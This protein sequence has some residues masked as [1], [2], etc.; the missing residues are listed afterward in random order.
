MDIVYEDVVHI[1]FKHRRLIHCLLGVCTCQSSGI[2]EQTT[3]G[4]EWHKRT[5][6]KPRVKTL[7]RLVLPHA[8]SPSSTSLRC[9]TFLPPQRGISVEVEVE[10]GVQ[11]MGVWRFEIHDTREVARDGLDTVSVFRTVAREGIWRCLM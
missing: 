1:V 11:V 3:Y 8:P 5:G 7:S 10:S 6:K 4:L 9:T 2:A